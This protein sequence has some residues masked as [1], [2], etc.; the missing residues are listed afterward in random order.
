[1]GPDVRDGHADVEPA[2][3]QDVDMKY[4]GEEKLPLI[5][6]LEEIPHSARA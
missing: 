2:G 5:Y 6:L 3:D 4:L 1:M